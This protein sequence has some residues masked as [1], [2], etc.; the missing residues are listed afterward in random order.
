[1]RTIETTAVVGN[2]RKVTVQLPPEIAPGPH[3]VVLV[4]DGP[5]DERPQTWTIADWPVHDAALV[6][7]NF[8]MRR[9]ELYGDNGR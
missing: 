5:L 1:M 9:E 3:Q 7:P 6:D 4:V 2:D 8:T